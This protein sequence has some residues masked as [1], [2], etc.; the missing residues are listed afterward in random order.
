MKNGNVYWSRYALQD[1]HMTASIIA[2]G[3]SW[4]WYPMPGGSLIE[5]IG[6][7]VKP[8]GHNILVA[9]NNGAEAYDYVKGKYKRQVKMMLRDYGSTASAFL[10][11]GGGND[12]AGFNDLRPMLRA[13]CA[14]ATTAQACFRDGAE[15]GTVG[16]LLDKMFEH[17]AM[18]VHRALAV[19]PPHGVIFVHCYDYAVPNGQGA[20]GGTPWLKPALD[21][22]KVPAALRQDCIRLLIDGAHSVLAAL[23]NG[24][25]GRVVVVDSRGT[26]SPADWANELH[27]RPQGFAKI[28]NQ[29]WR[30]ALAAHNLA[31]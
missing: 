2:C 11:S 15:E 3:D 10:I 12:F 29:H 7:L 22:A 4:F 21:D 6:K 16:F 19:M 24:A 25:A 28:A 1:D 18:L 23:A 17:Y 31:A 20:L 5:A 27:P 14:Q 9:G 26:L 13:N 30:P 8:K